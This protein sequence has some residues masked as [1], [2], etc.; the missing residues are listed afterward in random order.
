VRGQNDAELIEFQGWTLRLRATEAERPRQLVLIH[1]WTGD[2]NSMWVFARHLPVKYW[3]VAP[4]APHSTKP[5]G[6]S[7]RTGAHSPSTAPALSDL[8]QSTAGL[9]SMLDALAADRG[10]PGAA[11]NVMGFS[12][13]AALAA[14]IALQFPQRVDRIA[15]LAGFVP[16]AAE[17][18]AAALPLRGK[19]VFVAHG[20][21][22]ALVDVELGR[23]A[24][25]ILE[26]AGA[27]V[28]FCE[29]RVGHKVG[30]GCMRAL[31]AF[32]A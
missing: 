26:S 27:T 17:G 5:S 21:M 31:E 28:Q 15:L 8:Q 3:I 20:S 1:G 18:L 9:L 29:D 11:W 6:Y 30:A 32:F 23:R 2:E 14:T 13:G 25:Q 7:W 16:D 4:R 24:V 12:Q 19:Q 22:D 10:L